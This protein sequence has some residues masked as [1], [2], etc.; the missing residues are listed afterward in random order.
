MSN[1]STTSHRARWAA[2]G[3]AI[4]VTIGAGT[5]TTVGAV[6]SSGERS[7]FT[8]ITPCRL[9]DT[10]PGTNNVGAREGAIRASE[11]ITIDAKGPAGKCDA[12][13]LPADANGLVLNVTA[14]G[15]TETSFLTFWPSGEQ[16][17]AASLNPAPGQPPVPNAVTTSL[18]ATN[19][20]NVF[21]NSGDVHIVIDVAGYFTDHNHDDRYDTSAEVDAKIAANPGPAGPAGPAGTNGANGTN[22]ADGTNGTNGSPGA[23]GAN[24]MELDNVITVSSS[25]A[26]YTDPVAAVASITDASA[27]NPYQV[28]I[29]PGVYPLASQLIMQPFVHLI[30]SGR[31]ITVLEGT[32]T[33]AMLG[34]PSTGAVLL[35][36][37]V[38]ISSMSIRNTGANTDASTV[39]HG[40]SADR[41]T[42]R[43]VNLLV[44][45][46][47]STFSAAIYTNGGSVRVDESIV[48]NG[49]SLWGF[50]MYGINGNARAWISDTFIDA[51]LIAASYGSGLIAC[52]HVFYGSP[53][54]LNNA[55][56]EFCA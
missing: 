48:V 5:I 7:T 41:V 43:N 19:T 35:A 56:D 33:G 26:D 53:W 36:D 9:T 25:G 49:N 14:L 24:A 37:D 21:N 27:T 13:Q 1:R 8:A 54:S 39:L 16:P 46:G 18:S 40:D 32:F 45:N 12:T 38:E 20:F 52:D 3:A 17:L 23:A 10:R 31:D 51:P 30:G 15:A 22:G 42:L 50:G 29:G 4:A 28:L 2:I 47:S 34:T 6:Q 44:N 55:L 11:I